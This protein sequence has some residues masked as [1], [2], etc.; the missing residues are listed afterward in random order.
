MVSVLVLCTVFLKLLANKMFQWLKHVRIA[1][2]P[3]S[4]VTLA[5]RAGDAFPLVVNALM[6]TTN[7]EED[8][9]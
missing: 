2:R 1:K 9:V 5:V 7:L 3:I 8:R 4:H 6:L